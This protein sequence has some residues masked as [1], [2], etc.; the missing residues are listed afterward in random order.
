MG[1]RLKRVLSVVLAVFICFPFIPK[2]AENVNA[3]TVYNPSKAVAYARK[4]ALNY[5][6]AFYNY[7]YDGGDCANFVSQCLVEG[8]LAP[9]NNWGVYQQNGKMRGNT[10]WTCADALLEY[11]MASNEFKNLV[12]K[13]PSPSDLKAGNPIWQ[14][15]GHVVMCT[16]DGGTYC[17][18]T[19]DSLDHSPWVSI[20]TVRLDKLANQSRDPVGAFDILESPGTQKI[21]VRGWAF[22][23]DS[24][25][26]SI[27]VHVYIGG[28]AGTAGVEAYP[29]TANQT[30]DDVNRAY[31][32]S[33]KHGF[34]ATITVK[35]TG[36]QKVCIYAIDAQSINNPRIGDIKT[37]NI[38]KDTE[39]PKI[40]NARIYNVTSDGY[41]V[42]FDVSDN[43]GVTKVECPTWTDKGGQDDLIWHQATLKNGTATC[44]IKRSDHRN[45]YG[46]YL[47]HVYAWDNQSNRTYQPM[48]VTLVDPAS[49]VK[50]KSIDITSD[51]TYDRNVYE[52]D[53]FKLNANISPSNTTDKTII[54]KSSDTNVATVDS[55]GNVKIASFLNSTAYSVKI[56]ASNKDN[57][58]NASYKFRAFPK[59]GF[60][61]ADRGVYYN[62]DPENKKLTISGF[63]KIDPMIFPWCLNNDIK[64]VTIDNGVTNI[65]DYMFVKTSINEIII[66]ESVTEI[67][68][69]PFAMMYDKIDCL[70][71][72]S[73]V[74]RMSAQALLS[75]SVGKVI[76]KSDAPEL[77]GD[78]IKILPEI[79][80]PCDAVGYENWPC[81]I[82]YDQPA[83]RGGSGNSNNTGTNNNNNNNNSNNNNNGNNS[84][85]NN[86]TGN[87]STGNN[88][89]YNP[90]YSNEWVGGKWYNKAGYCDYAGTLSW[91]RD[92][93]GWW[94]EDSE[95]WYPTN[96]WQKIDGV[97]YFFKPDG[98]MASNEYYDGY[99]FNRDGSWDS[100]YCLRW[101]SNATG[102]WVED[103]SGW[104]PA[105]QWL[106]IDGYWYYF[107]ASGYMVTNQYVDGYWIGADGICR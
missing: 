74:K 100:A 13:D 92:S 9:N 44:H 21:R 41:D 38:M 31:G 69:Q 58:V 10:A 40:S 49:I 1:K 3:A 82:I 60:L 46:L 51:W 79:H 101:R 43:V 107:N 71:I 94:I 89:D 24:P 35:K 36:N 63:G 90:A 2:K 78:N 27:D 72:P 102:W 39:P 96:S 61:N 57:S 104:W 4:Y 91:K 12:V 67:G 66:P 42:A 52:G 37:V 16:A 85:G 53:T 47:T 103:V 88:K 54:W 81:D 84:T 77:Y 95:G 105:S 97:W 20:Y 98:Y 6:D 70:T 59:T 106:K 14:S 56:T 28:E 25:S 15:W 11:F 64:K 26:K 80:V 48:S 45:E 75:S 17:A 99:W 32:I 83:I 68:A 65:P 62:V 19:D 5:N 87:N 93:I 30:R 55:N 23:P 76:F 34:D 50:M 33:G 8:G 86:N 7:A 73:S 18:H 22:D 29:I